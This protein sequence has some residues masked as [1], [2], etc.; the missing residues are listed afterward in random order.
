MK[1]HK[2]L[3]GARFGSLTVTGFAG[4]SKNRKTMWYCKCDCGNTTGPIVGSNLRGGSPR[5]C[6]CIVR[7]AITENSSY[8]YVY[9]K[10]LYGIWHGMKQRCYYPKYKQYADYGGRGITVC[11]EW[12]NSF[13]AFYEW[14]I[15]NGYKDD[16]T[17]DRKDNDKGYSPENCCWSTRAEQ[18]KN[19]RFCKK[20]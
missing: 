9:Y 12:K 18:N 11:E 8:N 20:M 1:E 2:E 17:I 16:L 13:D 10:R 3:I 15:Q 19:R 14:A 5:S 7:D 4:V 6:G